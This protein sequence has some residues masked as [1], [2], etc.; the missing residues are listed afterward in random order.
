LLE[1]WVQVWI[2]FP[3]RVQLGLHAGYEPEKKIYTPNGVSL[4]EIEESTL[5]ECRVNKH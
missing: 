4:E 3:S 5:W 2:P 1:K